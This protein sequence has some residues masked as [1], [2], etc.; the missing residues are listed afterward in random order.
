[1]NLDF[2][3][4]FIE[5]LVKKDQNAFN[6][7]YLKTIDVFS[8][9]LN[10]NYF[11]DNTEIEDILAD[12]YVKWRDVCDKYKFEQ[13]FSAYVWTVFKNLLKD[14]F[15][16]HKDIPFTS[17]SSGN[18]EDENFEDTLQDDIDIIDF[19]EEEFQFKQIEQAMQELDTD[20]RELIYLKFIESKDNNEI[21]EI[22][23]LSIDNVRQKIF[24]ALKK[25]KS[26]LEK[27]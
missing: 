24:R 5:K 22:L 10:T 8:R 3:K 7:F 23:W 1:M 11:L 18:D 13:S 12:F 26:L 20:N 21:S 19:L 16:K 27:M 4:E 25:L 14:N 2:E 17:M 6:E 9:Y 15:K